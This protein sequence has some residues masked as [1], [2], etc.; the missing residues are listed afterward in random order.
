MFQ[1]PLVLSEIQ[2][3][4]IFEANFFIGCGYQYQ[5]SNCSMGISL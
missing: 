4:K 1:K 2:V 5:T 3:E